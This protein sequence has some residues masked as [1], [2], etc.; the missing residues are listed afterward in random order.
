MQMVKPGMG[1]LC[2]FTQYWKRTHQRIQVAFSLCNSLDAHKLSLSLNCQR[3]RN[4][5]I[6]TQREAM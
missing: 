2:L 4:F 5:K 6:K 1:E 3:N